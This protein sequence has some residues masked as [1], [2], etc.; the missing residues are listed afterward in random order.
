MKR[1]VTLSVD[2]LV[3]P[4][5]WKGDAKAFT[6]RLAV[7]LAARLAGNTAPSPSPPNSPQAAAAGGTARM[8][9]HRSGGGK[10]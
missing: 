7:E 9:A 1:P 3:V 2:R 8:I 4:A 5:A 6:D 10:R